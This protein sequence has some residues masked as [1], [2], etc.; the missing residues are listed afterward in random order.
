MTKTNEDASFEAIEL[1]AVSVETRGAA[2]GQ[3]DETDER[4]PMSG[5]SDD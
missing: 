1:G 4:L 5:I 3:R 2:I